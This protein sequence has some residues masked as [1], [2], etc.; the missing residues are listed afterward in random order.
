MKRKMGTLCL[1]LVMA[2]GLVGVNYAQWSDTLIETVNTTTGTAPV[3]NAN[4]AT[5]ITSTTATLNGNITSLGTIATGGYVTVSFEYTNTT[6]GGTFS[7]TAVANVTNMYTVPRSFNATVTNLAPSSSYSFRV[8]AVGLFGNYSAYNTVTTA[9]SQDRAPTLSVSG[10]EFTNPNNAFAQDTLYAVCGHGDEQRYGNFSFTIPPS[11]TINGI[12]VTMVANSTS[13]QT[14]RNFNASLYFGSS[15]SHTSTKTT[16]NFGSTESTLTVG[17]ATDTW[18]RT[19]SASE[20]NNT[21][22][23]LRLDSGTHDNGET[24]NLNYV[25]VTVYFTP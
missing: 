14:P 6:F 5:G 9:A 2:L 20:I 24:I 19:W 23:R 11:A 7:G 8:K 15:N 17:G 18:G 12:L 16:G 25:H 3:T 21:N 13:T 1:A 10:G 4:P 22:F